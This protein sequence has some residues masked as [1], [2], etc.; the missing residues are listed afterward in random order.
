ML[1]LFYR[2]IAI[3]EKRDGEIAKESTQ[4]L[5]QEKPGFSDVL[6]RALKDRRARW[7]HQKKVRRSRI[8]RQYREVHGNNRCGFVNTADS[9]RLEK[10]I[11]EGVY[12]FACAEGKEELQMRDNHE[13]A[14]HDLILMAEADKDKFLTLLGERPRLLFQLWEASID[15][16]QVERRSALEALRARQWLGRHMM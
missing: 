8:E 12:D 2:E 16:L 7:N 10:R 11:R 4:W 13:R 3:L 9:K 15:D 6:Q 5:I 14:M 1:G